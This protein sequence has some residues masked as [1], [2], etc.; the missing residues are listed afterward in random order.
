MMRPGSEVARATTSSSG[1]PI[2]RNFDIT[3][4]SVG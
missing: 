4:G 2:P 3:Q 1:M